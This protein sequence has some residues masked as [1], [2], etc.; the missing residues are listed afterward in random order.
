MTKERRRKERKKI[1]GDTTWSYATNPAV[2]HFDGTLF[3]MSQSGVGMFS[4]KC[5]RESSVIRIFA[6]GLWKGP[7]YATVMWCEEVGPNLY[8]AGLQ[9]N[10][11]STIHDLNGGT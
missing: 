11:S 1:L 5:L 4:E 6:K 10:P 2:P 7:R 9:F 3:D 8:R